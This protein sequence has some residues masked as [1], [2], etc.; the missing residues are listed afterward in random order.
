MAYKKLCQS[1]VSLCIN[2]VK[3]VYIH[4]TGMTRTFGDK[5]DRPNGGE[6]IWCHSAD[7]NYGP[8]RWLG[9]TDNPDNFFSAAWKFWSLLVAI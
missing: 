5:S 6:M 2:S 4:A 7:S 1:F 9:D 8:F 3:P